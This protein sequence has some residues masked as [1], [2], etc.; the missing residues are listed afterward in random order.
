MASPA[1]S[2]VSVWVQFVPFLLVLAIFY[3]VILLP[4]KRRQ[5]KVQLFLDALKVGDR[6]ITTSGIHG[7]I[8]K[9]GDRTVKVQVADKV[10]IELSRAAIAGYQGQDP[11][12]ADNTQ[13]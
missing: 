4:M 12:V 5:K 6:V 10:H 7:T 3:F 9:I 13:A 11:V 2:N 1:D 8:T